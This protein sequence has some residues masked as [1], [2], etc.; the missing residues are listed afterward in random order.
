MKLYCEVVV[1]DVLPALRSLVTRELLKKYR[2]NQTEIS[3]KLGITQP[4]VSQYKKELR[5]IRVKRLQSNREVIKLVESFSKEIANK[6]MTSGQTN[7]KFL[8]LSRKIIEKELK[9][10]MP[11]R[12][13]FKS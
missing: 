10:S 6:K 4:A 9:S 3:K 5:G 8:E 2:M 11:C 12:I 7:A 13:C 1:Q